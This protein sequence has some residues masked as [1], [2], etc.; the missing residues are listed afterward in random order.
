MANWYEVTTQHDEMTDTGRERVVSEKYAIEAYTV[1]EAEM[2]ATEELGG[3]CAGFEVV[4]AVQRNIRSI[5]DGGKED[6]VWYKVSVRMT[7]VDDRG[8]ET[9]KTVLL[10]VWAD[11]VSEATELAEDDMRSSVAD[12]DITMVSETALCDVIKMERDEK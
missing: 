4:G 1:T 3:A 2:R 12:W 7:S 5:V 10:L 8:K 6:G 9:R 11:S